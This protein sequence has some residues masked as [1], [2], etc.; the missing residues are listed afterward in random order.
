MEFG[1][2]KSRSFGPIAPPT[3][4]RVKV[5]Q[6]GADV[7]TE[8]WFSI[9]DDEQSDDSRAVI[10]GQDPPLASIPIE[11]NSTLLYGRSSMTVQGRTR[12]HE[13]TTSTIP[14]RLRTAI[15]VCW[16]WD[17]ER[18]CANGPHGCEDAHIPK[19]V[20]GNQSL[21]FEDDEQNFWDR[22]H[23]GRIVYS[24]SQYPSKVNVQATRRGPPMH[25]RQMDT[26][27]GKPSTTLYL[28]HDRGNN[29]D[30]M[31]VDPQ[32]P[33]VDEMD[34]YSSDGSFSASGSDVHSHSASG[35]SSL[36][37]FRER[38]HICRN[39]SKC[40][41]AHYCRFAHIPK[42][43]T[44]GRTVFFEDEEGGF[45][46]KPQHGQ[47]V[48]SRSQYPELGPPRPGRGNG[49]R[50]NRLEL[51]PTR[52]SG[53]SQ[54]PGAGRADVSSWNSNNG[55]PPPPP[56]EGWK[57]AGWKKKNKRGGHKATED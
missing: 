43:L 40:A 30:A 22:A 37:S 42:S 33:S 23:G 51:G 44:D 41:G 19:S 49:A 26:H 10:I 54:R 4:P 35:S 29:E 31:N 12:D 56:A 21:F 57:G 15:H 50:S 45:W 48:Y 6:P 36:L 18:F 14:R 46:D 1:R 27:E 52:Q 38:I 13:L 55:G 16:K 5:S 47:C 11:D 8:A 2:G 25:S 20:R 32:D 17:K 24:R 34:T 7:V 9:P 39:W 28:D 3:N 53:T